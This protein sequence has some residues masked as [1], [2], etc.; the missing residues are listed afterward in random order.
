MLMPCRRTY[1]GIRSYITLYHVDLVSS[2]S[3]V[4]IFSQ[5]VVHS[6][7]G[8]LTRIQ[9]NGKSC[10]KSH[11]CT[12]SVEPALPAAERIY[13]GMKHISRKK[14]SVGTWGQLVLS[15]VM[16]LFHSSVY[17]A[18]SVASHRRNQIHQLRNKVMYLVS[19]SINPNPPSRGAKYR[20]DDGAR[21]ILMVQMNHA[22]ALIMRPSSSSPTARI[23]VW[24]HC[25]DS[26]KMVT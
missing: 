23:C 13:E 6:A 22:M 14:L 7:F 9:I 26:W 19:T 12:E 8:C 24:Y 20:V 11:R 16:V 25:H 1:V 4:E 5:T 15:G 2:D 17:S 21:K 10:P 3:G 18:V